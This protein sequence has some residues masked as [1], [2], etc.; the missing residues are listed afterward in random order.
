MCRR[1]LKYPRMILQKIRTGGRNPDN[2][3]RVRSDDMFAVP[4]PSFVLKDIVGGMYFCNLRCFCLG[5][6]Q[7]AST[8]NL[9][10]E[11]KSVTYLLIAPSG[12]EH[13]FTGI[14]DVLRWGRLML[15]DKRSSELYG[16][17]RSYYRLVSTTAIVSH[18]RIQQASA[19]AN[20]IN[21]SAEWQI[22]PLSNQRESRN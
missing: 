3:R 1:G 16:I 9:S 8:P 20:Q 6:V 7:F 18:T 12:D 17:S 10:I 19:I 14:V 22:P 4:D 11:D 21:L 15:L 13:Q 2:N 5:S